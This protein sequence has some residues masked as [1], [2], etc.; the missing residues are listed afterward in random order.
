MSLDIPTLRRTFQALAPQADRL[1]SNFYDRLF[2]DFPGLQTLFL[3][4]DFN[5]QRQKLIQS[6]AVIVRSLEQP[7]V[8]T[9]YLKRLGGQHADLGVRAEDYPAVGQTL[10][11]VMSELAGPELWTDDVE[12]AW[13]EA[14]DAISTIMLTGAEEFSARKQVT[15]NEHRTHAAGQPSAISSNSTITQVP[16]GSVATGS[17]RQAA[18]PSAQYEEK[19]MSLD[20]SRNMTGSGKAGLDFSERFFG[21]VEYAPLPKMFVETDGT[22]SYL[23]QKANDLVRDYSEIL[24]V[25]PEELLHGNISQLYS[26]IPE[27]TKAL[28]GLNAP[29]TQRAVVGSDSIDLHLTPVSD[30]T[31]HRLG[32]LMAW[33]P[34]TSRVLAETESA[35]MLSMIENMPI[36]VMMA[37]PN[38]TVTYLNP[39]SKRKL[40]ELQQFLPIPVDQIVGKNID[41]FHKNPAYQRGLLAQTD[42]LPRR[43]NITVGSETLDLLVSPV[44][45]SKGNYL[46]PMVTWDVVTEK[47]RTEA[48]MVRVQNM[49]DNIPINVMLANRD[50]EIIYINPASLRTLKAIEH[51][52]PIPVDRIIGQKID[53]FHKAPERQR[54]L[55]SDPKNLPHR[56]RFQI[57]DEWADLLASPIYDKDKNY[58]GPMVTWSLVTTQVNLANEFERDVKGVV[59]IVTS[60]STELQASSKVMAASA[61]ETARQSQVVAAASEEATRN[62]ETVS[63]AAEELS[64]SIAEIARHV[65]DASRI[66]SQAVSEATSTNQKIKELGESSQQIGQ[67]IKVITSIAQQTNLL[68]LNATIEAARAGEAGKGFAVVANEVKELARQT[69][70]ATEE[71]SQKISAI[72]SATGD[73]VSAIGSIGQIIGKINE[74]STTI[75]SAVE[76]QTAATS[77]ISRNVSEAARGTAEV[78]NNISGVSQAATESGKGASDILVASEGLSQE[79][80]RLDAVTTEFLKKMRSL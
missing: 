40:A 26:V 30:K 68:A 70:K 5:E 52:L 35:R 6:L 37:D 74:I 48:E 3:N 23:N 54:R 75:A 44:R 10:L 33:E 38:L 17:A 77:E 36:N 76:E 73:A 12:H 21:M 16:R 53:I 51:L 32:T 19:P 58:L 65:Q 67:V 59:Q 31:G 24:G 8:L 27:L 4:T 46:G 80:V 13:I 69:A 14:L 28:R 41:I 64:A 18:E 9:G 34:V 79:S 72:Q 39:A 47:L 45:D 55:L 25:Q 43:A 66:S 29:R 71:I 61:E 1:A 78:S 63:S 50:F 2:E 22:V 15:Q 60:A 57:G 49:M 11:T 7:D 42:K 56:A 20:T 62:V